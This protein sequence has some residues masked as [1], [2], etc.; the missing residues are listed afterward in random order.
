MDG[1]NNEGG[2]AEE[3]NDEAEEKQ[4]DPTNSNHN[5]GSPGP[6]GFLFDQPKQRKKIYWQCIKLV[7]LARKWLSCPATSVASERV[8]SSCGLVQTAKR[9]RL[10]GKNIRNQVMI[11]KNLSSLN[12]SMADVVAEW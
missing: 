1:Q 4:D 8:F 6:P 2:A 5:K 12:I 11:Q 10:L 3:K 7:A 9:S